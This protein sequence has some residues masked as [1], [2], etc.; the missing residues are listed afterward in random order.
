MAHTMRGIAVGAMVGAAAILVAAPAEARTRSIT[1]ALSSTG[2]VTVTWHG[3][4]ARG[5]A[6]AGLCGYRGATSIRP[7]VDGQLFLTF[8]EKRL[9]DAYGFLDS[10]APSVSRV[11]R[12]EAEGTTDACVDVSPARELDL[13]ATRPRGGRVRLALAGGGLA[14]GR[15]AGPDLVGVLSR[16]PARRLSVA[17]LVRGHTTIDLSTRKPFSSGRFSGMIVSTLRLRLG[18]PGSSRVDEEP[19]PS[20][21]SKPGKRVRVVGVH[22]VYR[23]AGLEGKFTAAFQGLTAPLCSSVDACGVS[24]SA[25]WAVPTSGGRL[26]IDAGA[27][28][29]RSDRGLHG[30]LAAIRRGG[31]FVAAEATLTHDTGTTTA[32]ADRS[33][34]ESCH[35]VTSTPAP[36]LSSRSNG[37]ETRLTLGA[38]DIYLDGPDLLRAGCPGPSQ[39]G[40]LGRRALGTGTLPLSALARRRLV[41]RLTGGGHFDD[42]A[43]AGAWQSDFKLGLQRLRESV[44]YQFVRVSR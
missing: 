8:S 1:T 17:R 30:A 23:V 15:C 18:R 10:Q 44:K 3:D 7:T 6:A 9:N 42:G 36:Y 26:V 14:V 16:L 32:F 19:S 39:I 22:A 40:A 37:T 31:G 21:G 43:Y 38:P 24:G 33:G 4:P 2:A 34:G 41:L 20:G 28:A 27:P 25:K 11:Q 13:V 5:C 12:S 29:R 35:D